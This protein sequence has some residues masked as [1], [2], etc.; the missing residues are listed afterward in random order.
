MREAGSDQQRNR[1]RFARRQWA[2]RWLTWRYLLAALAL[3]GLLG[4]GAYAV[5]FSAW[6][7][8]ADVEVLGE[9]QLTRDPILQAAAV[10]TGEQLALVDLD[11]IAVRVRSLATVETVEVTRRWPDGVRIEVVERT[12]IAVIARG[13]GGYTQLDDEG[14]TFGRVDDVPEDLPRIRTGPGA[15]RAAISEAAAVVSALDPAVSELVD[16]VEVAT[17]D[18]IRLRLSDDREV[19]WG[20]AD[21]SEEKARVLLAFL[22]AEEAGDAEPARVY[23]VSV[24]GRPTTRG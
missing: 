12:P 8:V 21:A 20:S 23:D 14:V 24:P 18:R 16:D 11:A 7:R 13:A 1:K 3:V 6:L 5:F 19:R 2:R 9:E 22:N 10:P 15:D 17:V 4:F